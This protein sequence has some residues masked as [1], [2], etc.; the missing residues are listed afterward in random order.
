M[1]RG[2]YLHAIRYLPLKLKGPARHWLK[3][4]P[5]N[6]I[7]SWEEL[8]DAFRANFQ[9][10]YVR[11]LDANDLSHI[12]QQPREFARKLWNRFLTKKN[13]IVDCPDAEA[14]AA[15]KHSIRNEWLARHLGQEKPRTMA[16]L[17]S[18]MTAFARAK[19]VGWPVEA[20]ATQAHPKSGMAMG[21]HGTIKTSVK[22]MMRVLTTW[23]S[24][25]DSGAL[26]PVNGRSHLKAA[27]M[28]RPA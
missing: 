4:L 6:P 16:A 7:G 19:I 28:D 24:T 21:S 18:L 8:E 26:D 13:Q 27:K 5:E 2:D 11:P 25:P 9:G 12:I 15:F 22:T 10:T 20:P 23:R 17:T 3:S 1:A 14:L